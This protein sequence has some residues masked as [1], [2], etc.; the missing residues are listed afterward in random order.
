MTDD[1]SLD[2]STV[3][4]QVAAAKAAEDPWLARRRRTFGASD[5]P[6]LVLAYGNEWDPEDTTTPRYILDK[7][8][9][10]NYG[11]GT[12]PRLV[13]EKAGVR[14]SGKG[15]SATEAGQRRE[16]ELLLKWK[17][18]IP[19]QP[20]EGTID[21]DSVRHADA[22]PREWFP[23]VDRDAPMVAVTPDGWCRDLLGGNVGIELKCSRYDGE[24]LPWYWY[25]QKQAQMAACAEDWGIVVQGVNWSM[26]H[27]K[28][29]PVRS[30]RVERDEPRIEL[31][32]DVCRR[33]WDDVLKVRK[34]AGK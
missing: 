3:D 32:R 25:D 11:N 19:N 30:W 26:G 13:L 23:L 16:R 17:R 20:W 12:Y 34:E 33:A 6:A 9:P 2:F 8:R 29:G 28:D 14:A 10:N 21:V 24:E 7:A 22:A 4:G 18:G 31:I 1:L 5:V 27:V 15:N